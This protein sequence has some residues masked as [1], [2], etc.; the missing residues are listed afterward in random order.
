MLPRFWSAQVILA[1]AARRKHGLRT[2]Q[3][4]LHLTG[5]E[6][7]WQRFEQLQARVP[8]TRLPFGTTLDGLF[9]GLP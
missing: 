5:H 2:P 6:L 8:M 3:S 7:L 9:F 1:R 4:H